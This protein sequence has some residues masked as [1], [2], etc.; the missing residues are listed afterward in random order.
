[1][2]SGSQSDLLQKLGLKHPL[3]VAP[4]AG[5]PSSV[6][7]VA[8]SSTAGALGSMGAAYSNPVAI[9]QF[10]DAVRQ[11][12]DRPF[13]INLFIPAPV[14]RIDRS[15]V[16]RA[17]EATARYRAEFDLPAPDVAPPFEEDFDAQ[18]EAVL[19]AEPAVLSFVFGV[20]P[21]EHSRAARNAG[22]VLIGSATTF[23]EAQAL[24]D[25]DVDMIALQGFEA[26]GH[27]GI[28]DRNAAD[29]EIPRDDLLAQSAGRIRAPLIAAGGLMNASDIC[30][31]LR[32]GA[33]AVQMG[34]AF[35]VCAEAGTSAPYKARLLDPA[36]RPTRTTRAFSGRLA[37]GIE[38]RFMDEMTAKAD[39]ILPF[40]AQNKFT[41]D[42]RNASA[43]RGLADFLSLW[44]GSGRGDLWQGSAAAL[45][46]QLFPA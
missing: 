5:G 15:Q 41:R 27:R 14:P 25:S 45:I 13:A 44:A 21:A 18:F 31:V 36:G 12:T 46:D 22:I 29:Q 23:A 10:S 43:A 20:L 7:L 11:R 1:M 37:R 42:I 32:A 35:L 28:F 16:E 30:A 6:E 33:Q 19:K 3:I 9:A 38:N 8:A 26:G 39:A 2:P 24:D 40:Q 4:M 17:I 34:T